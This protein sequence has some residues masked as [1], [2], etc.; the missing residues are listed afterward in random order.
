MNT[1]DQDLFGRMLEP[2]PSH[3][4][5]H[6]IK[7]LSNKEWSRCSHSTTASRKVVSGDVA[8]T[9]VSAGRRR[10]CRQQQ[11]KDHLGSWEDLRL[12]LSFQDNQC[13]KL[14]FAV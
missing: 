7:A 12:Q 6:Y 1:S 9:A 13:F 14:L 4:D 3:R 11:Q 8:E 5:M 10:I 2:T